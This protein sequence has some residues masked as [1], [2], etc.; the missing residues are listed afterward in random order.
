M[1]TLP[2]DPFETV[3]ARVVGGDESQVFG[4]RGGEQEGVG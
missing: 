1:E 3:K 4:S 2:E